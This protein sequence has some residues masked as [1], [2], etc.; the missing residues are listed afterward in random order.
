ME[1]FI[2][3]KHLTLMSGFSIFF[4]RSHFFEKDTT[5]FSIWIN[6]YHIQLF[7][8]HILQNDGLLIF[9]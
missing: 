1:I 3:N 2:F 6:Q 9:I 4:F 5:K 8:R 7:G